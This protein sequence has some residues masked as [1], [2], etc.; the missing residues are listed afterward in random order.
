MCTTTVPAPVDLSGAGDRETTL[1]APHTKQVS[2]AHTF[3][4]L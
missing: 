1:K 2:C 4:N 3:N